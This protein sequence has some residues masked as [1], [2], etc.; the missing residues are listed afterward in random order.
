MVIFTCYRLSLR[1][2]PSQSKAS[3]FA[4]S[5]ILALL[6]HSLPP[7]GFSWAQSCHHQ[8][9][10]KWPIPHL[11]KSTPTRNSHLGDPV[12][13][14]QES[15]SPIFCAGSLTPTRC[16]RVTS[17]TQKSSQRLLRRWDHI[18]GSIASYLRWD[19]GEARA[20]SSVSFLFLSLSPPQTSSNPR[21]TG[22]KG[23]ERALW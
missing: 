13:T 21:R 22:E 14:D 20:A 2:D 3:S 7:P 12:P 11:E 16:L 23:R 19:T 4:R 18:L 10:A 15:T 9:E 17:V 8:Q 6:L 1:Q 5:R